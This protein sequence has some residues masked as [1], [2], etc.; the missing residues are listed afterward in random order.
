M[1]VRCS[2]LR[3]WH[4]AA[5][6]APTP[7]SRLHPSLRPALPHA[8]L[9]GWEQLFAEAVGTQPPAGGSAPAAME[10]SLPPPR[11]Q[12][13]AGSSAE[14]GMASGLPL[15]R[16]T[17]DALAQELQPACTAGAAAPAAPGGVAAAAATGGLQITGASPTS[18]AMAF[19]GSPL[20]SGCGLLAQLDLGEELGPAACALPLSPSL[21]SVFAGG[22]PSGGA[23]GAAATAGA[24]A[25]PPAAA[26]R[27]PGM[28]QAP[29]LPLNMLDTT[30]FDSLLFELG[31]DFLPDFDAA[32]GL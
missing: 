7:C 6:R 26:G 18:D 2:L 22:G 8:R 20:D 12:Q 27:P 31:P 19:I 24:A 23:A 15:T 13:V 4:D 5:A 30:R 25:G 14:A 10:I 28:L 1:V 9:Q 32:A 21:P 17:F 11:A 29:S 16:S 3:A